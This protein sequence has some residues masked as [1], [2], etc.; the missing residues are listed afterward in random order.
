MT[1]NSATTVRDLVMQMPQATRIFERFK[2][3]YCCGGN[4]PLIEACA[5]AGITL[6]EIEQMLQP[7]AVVSEDEVVDFNQMRLPTLID[8][9]IA[10]HH[11]YTKN[12]MVR[13]TALLMKVVAV[14][15]EN[16]PELRQVSALFARLCADLTPHMFKEEQILFPCIVELEYAA[17]HKWSAPFAPFGKVRYP[18][19][20][21]TKEH[22]TAGQILREIRK[23]TSD[24]L[25]PPD[26]CISYKT[27]YEALEVF[28]QDLHQHIHLENNILFPRALEL[29]GMI[30]A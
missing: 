17:V 25:V 5:T 9:I 8:H 24:Y 3:D 2:I 4:T 1:I 6:E 21:M 16:H 20:M 15:G 28:E 13:L 11:I 18:V 26:V 30:T 23:T 12:E 22:D 7:N 14:H 10:R 27:L 19:G 29:E